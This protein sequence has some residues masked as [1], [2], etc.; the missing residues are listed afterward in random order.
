[1]VVVP[2]LEKTPLGARFRYLRKRQGLTIPDL[3]RRTG[4]SH[5]TISRLERGNA[6]VNMAAVGK[7]MAYFG[8]DWAEA[9]PEVKHP[10]DL[11]VPVTDFG[12][13]LR[14]FRIRRGLQQVELAGILGVS[15][16]SVCR[17]ER[18]RSRPSAKIT[19]R[20]RKVFKLNGERDR[21]LDSKP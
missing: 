11:L 8:K 6:A 10:A 13:W 19:E 9:C 7:L 14:N 2:D 17:Y 1:M 20:L 16:V 4:I 15:K 18:N 21:F 5:G 3:E 12:S